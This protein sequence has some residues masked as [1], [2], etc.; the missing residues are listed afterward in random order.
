MSLHYLYYRSEM[1]AMEKIEHAPK[2]V[3]SVCL[4]YGQKIDFVKIILVKS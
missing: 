1:G 2:R 4:I 3:L